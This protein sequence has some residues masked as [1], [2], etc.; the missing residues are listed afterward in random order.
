MQNIPEIAR[1]LTLDEKE[2]IWFSAVQPEISYPTDGNLNCLRIEEKSFWFNHRNCCILATVKNF[3]PQGTLFDVGG[4]NGF[5]SLALNRAGFPT[6]LVETGIEGARNAKL[7]RVPSVVCS[8]LEDAG[9]IGNTLPA[10]GLF[11]VLEHIR[12]DNT[13]LK[14]IRSLLTK[15]GRLY[16]TVPAHKFLWSTDDDYAGHYRRYSLRELER[17][18]VGLGFKIEYAT[19]FFSFLPLPIFLSRTI[20]SKLGSRKRFS[21]DRFERENNPNVGILNFLSNWFLEMELSRIRNRET[22]AFGS[23]ILLVTRSV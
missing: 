17:Q 13:F 9:F 12:D 23:S 5:V 16:L 7:R 20:P 15:N 14:I 18:I 11:D 21:F 1:N 3:P 6:I 22:Q 10:I 4:G 2:G 19:Y 8:T